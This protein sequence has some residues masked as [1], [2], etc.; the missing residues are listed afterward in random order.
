MTY[1]FIIVHLSKVERGYASRRYRSRNRLFYM[2][3]G[4]LV[5]GR[6]L[7][8]GKAAFDADL[9]S[10]PMRLQ[11]FSRFMETFGKIDLIHG[12][13]MEVLRQLPDNAF[14]IGIVDP[15]YGSGVADDSGGGGTGSDRDSIGTRTPAQIRNLCGR[16]ARYQVP[17]PMRR[18]RS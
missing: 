13:C 1:S 3:V 4:L 15:P 12:D 10:I 5:L 6:A 16:F 17:P 9:G 2:G 14:D 18:A 8:Y 11:V 7:A